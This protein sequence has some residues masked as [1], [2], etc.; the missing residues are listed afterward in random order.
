MTDP[1]RALRWS[2]GV[3]V[4]LFGVLPTVMVTLL[5][6]QGATPRTV[7]L[8]LVPGIALVGAALL[9]AGRGITSDDHEAAARW[10]RRSMALVA[11]ADVL[12]LGGNALIR[13]A[14]G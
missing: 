3:A 5:V 1:V 7:G 14:A 4:L 13:M 10:M 8:L 6:V 9:F 2:G 12:L 11:T